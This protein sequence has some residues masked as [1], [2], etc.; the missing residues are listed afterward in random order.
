MMIHLGLTTGEPAGVGPEISLKAAQD[1]LSSH[2]DVVI[3]LVG[4]ESLFPKSHDRL[5]VEHCPLAAPVQ[6]GILNIQ[7]SKYVLETLDTAIASCL[8]GKYDAMVTAP[9]QKEC[10][11]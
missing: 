2:D 5:I 10:H 6:P 11:C 3:H 7:N 8:S 1:Y 4:D 9:V